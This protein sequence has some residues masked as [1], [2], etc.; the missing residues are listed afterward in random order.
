MG[1]SEI[2][3]LPKP[4]RKYNFD[5]MQDVSH[6]LFPNPCAVCHTSLHRTENLLCLQCEKK[7]PR[8]HFHR[9]EE[10]VVTQ[11]FKV[12]LPL[13]HATA[14]LDFKKGNA[15][16]ELLHQ[17]KY[18]GR[19]ELGLLLGRLFAKDL[20]TDGYPL[21]DLIIPL[22]L[23]P[24]KEKLRG[25]NQSV[26]ISMGMSE[27]LEIPVDKIALKRLVANT[28]Q[29][30]KARYERWENVSDIFEV[31]DHDALLGRH[32]WLIDDVVTTGATLEACGRKLLA[33]GVRKLSILTLATA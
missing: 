16:Q 2:I 21:S 13:Q 15:A 9:L 14:F 18:D 25:F 19:Q 22:P 5:W 27:I 17:L 7:L 6:L 24:E 8:T 20:L 12:R 1:E 4:T 28:T 23:H 29:T 31:V 32:I 11:K 33:A 26:V 10:N 3:L 30:R